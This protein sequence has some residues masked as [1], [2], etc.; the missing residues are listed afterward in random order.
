MALVTSK[1]STFILRLRGES[2]SA[3]P[4]LI[5]AAL[6]CSAMSLVLFNLSSGF[7][8]QQKLQFYAD[9][10]SLAAATGPQHTLQQLVQA[11]PAD[12][13]LPIQM[14]E[15]TQEG[16]QANVRICSNWR[17]SILVPFVPEAKLVCVTSSAR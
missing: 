13:S 6:F 14:G 7:A 8:F 4:L 3:L 17:P 2:G 10:I 12:L 11:I 15:L 1:P 5:G 9:Q 16:G